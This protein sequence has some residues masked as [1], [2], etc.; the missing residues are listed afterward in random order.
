MMADM[1]KPKRFDILSIFPGMFDCYLNESMIKRAKARKLLDIRVHDIREWTT[2]NHRTV[3]DRPFGGG[4]GMVLKV[5]PIHRGLKAIKAAKT[6]TKTERKKK[7]PYVLMMSPR[8]TRFT[9]AVA[10]RLSGHDRI[11]MLCGRYEGIDQRVIDNLVDEEISIG[12]YV[13]T[14]GELPA[15]VVLDAV[16]RFVP[17]V[18]GKHASIVEESHSKPGYIEYP[19]Y[20]RPESYEA[21]RGE[22]WNVPGVLLSGDHKKIEAWREKKSKTRKA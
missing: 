3:D 19:H 4:P 16:S 17:G 22:T 15:M 11:V 20:T 18:V 12:D 1:K 6:G 2:D 5:G 8:G 9:Q 7:A 10:E 14:G 21:K 13:L